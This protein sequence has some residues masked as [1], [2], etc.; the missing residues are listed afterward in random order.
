[1]GLSEISCLHIGLLIPCLPQ[2]H[3]HAT[4]LFKHLLGYEGHHHGVAGTSPFFIYH[5]AIK[6][7]DNTEYR[8]V[9]D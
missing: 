6:F 3:F 2:P 9:I 8:M 7:Q 4:S 5:F 1:M